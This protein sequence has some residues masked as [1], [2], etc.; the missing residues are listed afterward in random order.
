[1]REVLNLK[2]SRQIYTGS[3]CSFW[4]GEGEISEIRA[5]NMYQKMKFKIMENG[6]IDVVKKHLRTGI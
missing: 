1:M 3:F 4:H 2:E 5:T 6:F